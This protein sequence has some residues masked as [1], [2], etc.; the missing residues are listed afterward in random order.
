MARVSLDTAHG[1]YM[2][3]VQWYS[4]RTY[5]KML[6]PMLAMAHSKRAI[7]ANASFELRIGKLDKLD[8]TLSALAV[9]A[10]AV[11]LGCSWCIDFGYWIS[12]NDGVDAAKLRAVPQWR[13]SEIFTE[14]ERRVLAYS[15]AMTA[16]PPEVTDAMAEELRDEL[17]EAAL[18]ELTVLVAV[19]N[20]RSRFNTAMGLRGQGF[21]QS[22]E[23]P[24]R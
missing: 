22:C 15:E 18:V 23:V 13:T 9:M 24:P 4:K 3:A 7:R 2:K 12:H 17:G 8:K 10:P 21:A 19:E 16:S 14:V 5:G 6:E 1:P 20:Q 11:V